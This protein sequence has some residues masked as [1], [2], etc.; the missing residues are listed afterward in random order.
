WTALLRRQLVFRQITVVRPRLTPQTGAALGLRLQNRLSWLLRPQAVASGGWVLRVR[1]A[2]LVDGQA[3]WT[4]P[5]GAPGRVEGLEG[6]F[7]WG[8]GPAA[9]GAST[10][11]LQAA[12]LTITRGDRTHRLDQIHLQANGTAEAVTVG[13]AGFHLAGARVSLR[14]RIADPMHRPR[15][16]LDLGVQAPLSAVLAL[17]GSNRQIDG[18]LSVD[19]RLEGPWEQAAFQG[20]GRLQLGKEREDGEA[21]PFSLRW[22]DG[23]VEVATRGGAAGRDGSFEGE[24]S[25]TPTTG[26][27]Q[28]RARLTNTNLAALAGLP[29]ALPWW[30]ADVFLPPEIRGRLTGD[31]DL[32]GQ[33]SDLTTVRGHAAIAVEGLALKGETPSGQIEAR[34]AATGSRLDVQA[35]ALRTAGGEV[36]CRGGL[37]FST[38]RLHLP[39]RAKLWDVGAFARGFGATF[40]RGRA[41]LAGRVTGTWET[42]HLVGRLTWREAQIAA[43]SF[44]LIEGEIDVAHRLLR[45][46]RL[47]ART[48]GSTA[49][50]RGSVQAL[51]TTPL[52]RLNPKRD[53]A[54]DIQGSLSPARTADFVSLLPDDLEIRGAFRAAGRIAGT[55]ESLSGEVEVSLENVRTWEESWRRGEALFQFRQGGVEIT[56]ILLRRR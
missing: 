1:R 23:R 30:Q 3:A 33:G 50:I 15:L 36:R 8:D 6:V 28:V 43:Q 54:L 32:S 48:G 47:L 12:H 27:Y 56:R 29:L 21:L 49:T 4:G 55:L 53:L 25:L 40:L 46:P 38:G 34:I 2:T 9:D 17:L 11:Q 22:G 35:F 16:E 42:P 19:G 18:T 7:T 45:T 5:D 10:V 44:D 52:R 13:A 39:V 20:T 26:L 51:G 24:L 31:V 14:G 41:T 37:S